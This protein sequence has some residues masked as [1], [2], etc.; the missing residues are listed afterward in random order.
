MEFE[1]NI[2]IYYYGKRLFILSVESQIANKK[3]FKL[4]LLLV[5][6]KKKIQVSKFTYINGSIWKW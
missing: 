3:T 5:S 1:R 2:K 4:E 6:A